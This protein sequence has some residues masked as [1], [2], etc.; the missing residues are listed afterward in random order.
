VKKIVASY[1]IC[2][3][4]L[5]AM[6]ALV[7]CNNATAPAV[8]PPASKTP[9]DQTAAAS[10]AKTPARADLARFDSVITSALFARAAKHP[11]RIDGF[12]IDGDQADGS[13]CYYASSY[14]A[15]SELAGVCVAAAGTFHDG[16]LRGARVESAALRPALAYWGEVKN[17]GGKKGTAKVIVARVRGK[18]LSD[19]PVDIQI[20]ILAKQSTATDNTMQIGDVTLA[21]NVVVAL[22]TAISSGTK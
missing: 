8:K 15:A 6:L 19:E 10:P 13:R 1:L 12:M 20:T 17:A 16:T 9:A 18:M 4:G 7:A 14:V 21:E 5:S 22:T 3:V 2:G 11:D